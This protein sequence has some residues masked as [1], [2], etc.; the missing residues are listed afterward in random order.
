MENKD[1]QN[2]TPVMEE[3]DMW[4]NPIDH[5]R[6]K[7]RVASVYTERPHL[8]EKWLN[9]KQYFFTS[10]LGMYPFFTPFRFF[11]THLSQRNRN[12]FLVEN[13]KNYRPYKLRQN[14][15]TSKY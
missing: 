11:A 14:D 8:T 3:T 4:S 2:T 1:V 13:L 15:C 10:N 6:L 7:S 9:F 12:L 5:L